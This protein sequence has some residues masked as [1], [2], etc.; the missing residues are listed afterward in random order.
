MLAKTSKVSTKH[1]YN[2]L[3]NKQMIYKFTTIINI[4]S[5][6]QLMVWTIMVKQFT[7]APNV[8]K[9]HFWTVLF[10]CCPFFSLK[11]D[12]GNNF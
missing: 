8:N 12:M 9:K 4:N 3:L 5:V 10:C 11:S 2:L 6:F 1:N 7:K